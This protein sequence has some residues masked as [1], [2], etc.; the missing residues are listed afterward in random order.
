MKRIVVD[1]FYN[2]QTNIVNFILLIG[3]FTLLFILCG[4][5]T[6]YVMHELDNTNILNKK[7]GY[8][9]YKLYQ[10]SFKSSFIDIWNQ[11]FI[12]EKMD[13]TLD[14]LKQ[15]NEFI[16]TSFS[17]ENSINMFTDDL[18]KHFNTDLYSNFL[19]SSKGTN[20]SSNRIMA[21]N[22]L[23]NKEIQ[24]MPL[25]KVDSNAL[26]HYKINVD[27]G[28]TFE[29]KDFIFDL[30][31]NEINI[32][33]G[34]AYKQYYNL[35]EKIELVTAVRTINA[36]IVGFVA[37]E[38]YIENDTTFEHLGEEKTTIDYSV[39]MP[40]FQFIGNVNTS[41]EKMFVTL[42]YI[43]NLCGTVIFPDSM[44]K[45]EIINQ[46]R[47]INDFFIR[48]EVFTVIT[49]ISTNGLIYFQ[50]EEKITIVILELFMVLFIIFNIATLYISIN[51]YIEK[52]SYII[53]VEMLNGRTLIQA[54]IS[55]ML[56]AN[57]AIILAIMTVYLHDISWLFQTGKF[58]FSLFT[59]FIFFSCICSIILY[60]KIKKVDI[61]Y[62]LRRKEC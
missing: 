41:E 31:K 53:A 38:T 52:K 40:C 11:P 4:N 47:G 21:E 1:V 37:K 48:N 2:I 36:T 22:E 30:R 62:E 58:H 16:F 5:L 23:E 33:L 19:I 46:M 14:D 25:C 45:K 7:N 50:G 12:I 20:S 26:N 35:G 8:Q 13:A 57:F 44:A 60:I 49:L 15:K 42:E 27:I 43:S 17:T 6:L 29:P 34:A 59:L 24:K 54:C 10:H 28:R 56:E 61:D 51:Q 39:V 3:Q 55:Y 32:L 9:Y 18:Q